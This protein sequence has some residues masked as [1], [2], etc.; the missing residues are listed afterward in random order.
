MNIF[1]PPRSAQTVTVRNNP[2]LVVAGK[3]QKATI[4]FVMSACKS[5]RVGQL[6]SHGTNFHEISYLNIFR[7]YVEEIQVPL[8]SDMN[9]RHFTRRPMYC[10]FM[11]V[12]R[13]YTSP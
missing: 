6:G 5:I 2:F 10:T 1:K 7:S 11:A 3:Q 13:P 8:K 9:N 12:F 4:S